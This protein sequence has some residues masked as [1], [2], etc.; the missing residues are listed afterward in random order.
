MTSLSPSAFPELR[1]VFEGYLH[2]DVLVEHG[3]PEAALR[4]FRADAAPA[5]VLRFRSEV[6]RFL[7]QTRGLD[8]DSVRALVSQL[9]CRW[10]PPSREALIALLTETA[11]PHDPSAR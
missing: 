8:F 1:R 9:G 3:T 6:K 5:D 2:E 4:A 10:I 7:A 11:D